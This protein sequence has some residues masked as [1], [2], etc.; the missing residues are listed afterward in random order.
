[1]TSPIKGKWSRIEKAD[2]PDSA[3]KIYPIAG[4]L[5][6]T[7]DLLIYDQNDIFKLD[8]N[9]KKTV[10][11]LTEGRNLGSDLV[12][13]LVPENMSLFDTQKNF[14]L[15]IFDRAEKKQ[16]I[17]CLPFD[18]LRYIKNL[19]LEFSATKTNILLKARDTSLYIVMQMT[20]EQSPNLFSTSDL[21]HFKKLSDVF[22][23]RVYNWLTSELVTWK[24]PDGKNDQGILYKP[25]D[26]NPLKK[27]PMLIYYYER[28]SDRLHDFIKPEPSYGT[29][30][31]PFFVSRG[32]LVFVPDI[33]YKVGW[34][35]K[36]AYDAIV[37]GAIYLSKR[38]YVDVKRMGLQGMSFGGFE[39]N[40]IVTHTHLFAAAMSSSGFTD[41]ISCYGSII[42]GG[43]SRQGTFELAR[44]RIGATMWQRPDLY[45]ENSPILLA[46]KVSTPLLMMTNMADDDVP[47]QQGIELFTALRRLGKKVWMLQ[48]DGE[49]HGLDGLQ[50]QEDLTD[51]MFQFFNYY[52]KGA[53]P[54]KWMTKGIPAE[55]KGIDTGLEL[56]TSGANP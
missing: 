50:A 41:F 23:E 48:Y 22:P 47:P 14:L 2:E 29:V 43:S 27:Y 17:I 25:E 30:N 4:L 12:F 10:T 42:G 36:C 33:H 1:M 21:K 55:L 31:I 37:S 56:D 18:S 26:F 8:P 19:H 28:F 54:P 24:T 20:A 35:G 6:N 44:E 46:D 7:D 40:Y 11:R 16:A 15:S 34:T 38:P 49:G 45:I 53:P 5:R 32:Y 52:L 9:G 3:S 51:R 39:T 13:R